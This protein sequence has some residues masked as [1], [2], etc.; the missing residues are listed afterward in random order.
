MPAICKCKNGHIFTSNIIEDS[1]E[2][3]VYE[4]EATECPECKTD[5]FIVVDE[6][7]DFNDTRD[8]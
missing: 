6:E 2:I 3:N 8:M 5:E 4:V 7:N 1:P